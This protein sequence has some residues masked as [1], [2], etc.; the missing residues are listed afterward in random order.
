MVSAL[1]LTYSG[2]INTL[3]LKISP[4]KRWLSCNCWLPNLFSQV[5]IRP[6]WFGHE[7]VLLR[8]CGGAGVLVPG[9]RNGREYKWMASDG[10]AP[11]SSLLSSDYGWGRNNTRPL[12]LRPQIQGIMNG[13][14][15]EKPTSQ[16]WIGSPDLAKMCV[17]WPLRMVMALCTVARLVQTS[18]RKNLD[19][20]YGAQEINQDMLDNLGSWPVAKFQTY[21]FGSLG[22]E[23]QRFW[24]WAV[25]IWHVA[26]SYWWMTSVLSAAQGSFLA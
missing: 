7:D 18:I 11:W 13:T 8:C 5:S 21:W 3:S 20:L 16:Q 24:P 15:T 10:C 19:E 17:S 23:M 26:S 25:R 1:L 9:P 6:D 2:F 4:I 12:G 22:I 14:Y